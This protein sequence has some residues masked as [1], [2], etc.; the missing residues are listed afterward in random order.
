MIQ[1]NEI[2]DIR[3]ITPAGTIAKIMQIANKYGL[4]YRE[5]VPEAKNK[6]IKYFMLEI[7]QADEDVSITELVSDIKSDHEF[8]YGKDCLW[9]CTEAPTIR[10]RIVR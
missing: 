9:F 4:D 2:T 8:A 3:T 7:W 6:R 1:V 10:R 5:N